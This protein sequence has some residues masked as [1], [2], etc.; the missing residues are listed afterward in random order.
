MF[1]IKNIHYAVFYEKPSQDQ[2]LPRMLKLFW[3]RFTITLPKLQYQ[4]HCVVDKRTLNKFPYLKYMNMIVLTVPK[5]SFL[6]LYF[7][8]L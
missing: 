8:S 4:D 3:S 7:D 1:T 5:L 6:Q 2:E